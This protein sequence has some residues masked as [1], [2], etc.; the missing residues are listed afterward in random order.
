MTIKK[1]YSNLKFFNCGEKAIDNFITSGF[2]EQKKINLSVCYGFFDKNTIKGFYSLTASSIVNRKNLTKKEN[3]YPTTPVILIGR[4]G[5]EKKYQKNGIGK[6]LM[7]DAIKRIIS[8]SEEVGCSLIV[9]HAKNE[10]LISY[11]EK[12]GFMP[13]PEKK[14]KTS[15]SSNFFIKI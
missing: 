12:F 10:S 11:Y 6:E 2:E 14:T 13:S 4:L 9:P 3:P 15:F 7:Q 1:I 8:V 5:V